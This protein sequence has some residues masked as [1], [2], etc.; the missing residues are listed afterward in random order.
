MANLIVADEDPIEK[1]GLDEPL[2]KQLHR[3]S[4]RTVGSLFKKPHSLGC[5]EFSFVVRS[6]LES[7][8]LNDL[9][10]KLSEN[11]IEVQSL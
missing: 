9:R 3:L 10:V 6:G 1:L 5:E 8:Q 11:G 2:V 7:R 4:K